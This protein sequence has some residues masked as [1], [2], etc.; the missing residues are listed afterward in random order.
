MK[1]DST[2]AQRQFFQEEDLALRL[3]QS[4]DEDEVD[5]ILAD[6]GY[7]LDNKAAWKPLGDN[8]GNFQTVGNQ[9]EDGAAA[10]VEKLINSVDA[11][12]LSECYSAGIDPK[13]ARAPDTM[14]DAVEK[15]FGVKKGRLDF[16]GPD[17]QRELS[18]KIHFV[19]TGS[20][21]SPCYSIIDRGEGQTPDS[22][23][24]TFLVASK[25]SP[26][27]SINFVQ[28]KFAAGGTGSLQFSGKHNIQLIISRR[29]PHAQSGS[30]DDDWGFTV[31]R[32]IRPSTVGFRNSVFV[33][34]APGGSIP[35]FSAPYLNLL[36][37]TSKKSSPV[38]AYTQPLSYGSCIKLYNYRWAGRSTA[39][40]EARRC[41]ERELQVPCLPFRISESRSFTANYYST[42]VTGVW[43]DI[44]SDNSA[45]K[46]KM[47]NG[48]P[49]SAT[50]SPSNIGTLPIDLA[51]WDERFKPKQLRRLPTGVFFLVNGQVHGSLGGEF[52]SKLRHDYISEHLLVAVDCTN[53]NRDVAE[54]L[55][56]PSRDRLRKNE[57]Y[58]DLRTEL[59]SEL[60]DHPGLKEANARRRQRARERAANEPADVDEIFNDLLKRDPTLATL[61]GI[62]GRL[63]TGTGPG[64]TVRFEGRPFPSYFRLTAKSKKQ[65]T[66]NCPV[67][68][69][70]KVEFET[71]VENSYFQRPNDPGELIV[72]PTMDLVESSRLWNGRMTFKFRVPWDAKE[73]DRL[74]LKVGVFDVSQTELLADEFEIVA[75]PPIIRKKKKSGK[76]NPRR[77]PRST[78]SNTT[79]ATLT[80]PM[81]QE[82]KK[83]DWDQHGFEKPADAMRIKSSPEGNGYDFYVNIDNS[84]L[85]NAT[86]EKK[87]D[88]GLLKYWFTWGLTIAAFGMIKTEK[89]RTKDSDDEPDLKKISNACD[90][91]APV[92]IPIIRALHAGPR[93][94]NDV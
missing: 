77:N 67:N 60:R 30:G 13:S 5:R 24:S 72:E 28:G 62:G 89:D 40:L 48:F 59:L 55:F 17:E 10:L 84:Y 65:L 44:L 52:V 75:S 32:R 38:Q 88:S 42:T 36:P 76:P 3:L 80:P 22:F 71:D 70:V 23:P 78:S 11:V 57:H 53:M 2:V 61:L 47:E 79:N 21:S 58:K 50:V 16:L 73:G 92:I 85:L 86:S 43:A 93:H 69:T 45:N 34:L 4:D 18:E 51:V 94:A 19:A 49:G 56:M 46:S 37:G 87:S 9:Q 33:Y 27:A 35:R 90:G 14:R 25:D 68:S 20:K 1:A 29:Q 8:M 74:R 7:S 15:F 41:L 82:V 83:A 91:L 54:D 26:K 64:L 12:L 63:R 66:K 81:P 39:T 31:I 6:A